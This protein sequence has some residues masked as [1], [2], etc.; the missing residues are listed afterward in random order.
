M[1]VAPLKGLLG[2]DSDTPAEYVSHLMFFDSLKI[3]MSGVDLTD[4]E[5]EAL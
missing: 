5:G 1:E 3:D 2:G 4:I